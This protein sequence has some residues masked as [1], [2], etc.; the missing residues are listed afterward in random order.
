MS[1]ETLRRGS[2]FRT[3]TNSREVNVD[4]RLDK[5]PA[6]P[7]VAD[8][9][10]MHRLMSADTSPPRARN[11][12]ELSFL[13]SLQSC[14]HCGRRL[15]E[16]LF[17][18]YGNAV[19]G[20]MTGKC[21]HCLETVALLVRV[22]GDPLHAA[23]GESDELGPGTSELIPPHQL[24][25]EVLALSP[26]VKDDPMVLPPREWRHRDARARGGRHCRESGRGC[27]RCA[28]ALGRNRAP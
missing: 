8:T 21:R 16:Q 19:G 10:R 11:L 5:D 27:R 12:K 1:G 9:E 26:T 18:Y 13:V 15:D 3:T 2:A 25:D 23:S 4:P 28:A 24:I 6:E 17:G 22:Q 14:S 7:Y 20:S